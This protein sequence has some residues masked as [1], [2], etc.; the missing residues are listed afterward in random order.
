MFR[1]APRNVISNMALQ[2]PKREDSRLLA[3]SDLDRVDSEQL[4]RYT[5]FLQGFE[6]TQTVHYQP[7]NT[8]PLTFLIAL[9]SF[10]VM[11]EVSWDGFGLSQEW[12]LRI[13]VQF[14]IG[15]GTIT[16]E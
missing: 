8:D 1:K 6:T 2:G 10:S 5:T 15:S 12:Q 13:V 7:T 3:P 11:D 4:V 14:L 16:P 9:N